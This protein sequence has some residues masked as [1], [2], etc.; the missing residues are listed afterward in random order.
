MDP[1]TGHAAWPGSQPQLQLGH[2]DGCADPVRVS[3]GSSG[4]RTRR[5]AA[6]CSVQPGQG[7]GALT[8][9]GLGMDA[10]NAAVD[11]GNLNGN[12]KGMP[13]SDSSTA[14]PPQARAAR[15]GPIERPGPMGDRNPAGCGSDARDRGP[16]RTTG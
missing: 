6:G 7:L 2:C 10:P 12:L 8:R 1:V 16:A 14:S 5:A 11:S 4:A 9:I 3:H 15:R 13:D